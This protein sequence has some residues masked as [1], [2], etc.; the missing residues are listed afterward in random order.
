MFLNKKKLQFII[1]FSI[2][3]TF[4]P[5]TYLYPRANDEDYGYAFYDKSIETIGD[6]FE[7]TLALYMTKTGRI[8]SN[9]LAAILGANDWDTAF[10]GMNAVFFV[11][12]IFFMVKVTIKDEKIT[13]SKIIILFALI[14]FLCKHS[15][16]PVKFQP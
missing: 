10:K 12:F 3:L 1:C 5:L 11:L 2:F 4:I 14:W 9:G 15:V 8:W 7:S 6:F 13:L 16:N